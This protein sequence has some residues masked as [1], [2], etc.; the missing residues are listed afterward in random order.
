LKKT[1]KNKS[2]KPRKK[3]PGLWSS[4]DKN[5]STLKKQ[6]ADRLPKSNLS[7][8]NSCIDELFGMVFPQ[9]KRAIFYSVERSD[10]NTYLVSKKNLDQL[11]FKKPSFV[12]AR[13]CKVQEETVEIIKIYGDEKHLYDFIIEQA[14]LRNHFKKEILETL[15]KEKVPSLGKRKDLRKTPFVTID[16]VDAKDF[17]DAVYANL[18]PDGTWQLM[19]AIADVTHYLKQSSDLD[20]EA[21]QRGNSI[22]F[23]GFVIP[24]L[25]EKLSNDLCSLKPNVDRAVLVCEMRLNNKGEKIQHSFY[26]ALIHSHAR[27]TYDQVESYMDG[28]ISVKTRVKK[29][30][31]NLVNLYELLI[32]QREIR[33]PL[34]LESTELIFDFNQSGEVCAVKNAPQLQSQK[35]IEEMMVLAN[36]C[37]AE[38]LTEAQLKVPYRIHEMP[39]AEKIHDLKQQLKFY[40][41]KTGALTTPEGF[42]KIIESMS[43]HPMRS[44]IMDLCLRTQSKAIYDPENKGHFGLNL[45]H[46]CHFTSPIRRYADVLV[47]RAIYAVIQG[48]TN[49]FKSDYL[50][51]SDICYELSELERKATRVE[52]E[53]NDRLVAFFYANNIGSVFKSVISG[54]SGAGI[55][56]TVPDPE[57]SGLIVMENLSDDYYILK[58]NPVHLKG[59]RRGKVYRIGQSIEVVLESVD[60]AKGRLNFSIKSQGSL[61][62]KNK[63]KKPFIRKA[64]RTSKLN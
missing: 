50:D 45:K 21:L 44:T 40:Q 51:M 57:I 27:L 14:N 11:T 26:S 41:L 36:R 19:V 58:N 12:K 13:L 42:N 43:N 55:F 1:E 16:G 3:N 24:M 6:V 62:T 53:V 9:D 15:K 37:A 52:R 5:N 60:L 10:R 23:P 56:V 48:K 61:R 28:K 2:Y 33:G 54:I 30:V 25:P 39:V 49:K 7:D 22:Y 47:H 18:N 29:P 34:E 38:T 17:D 59:R 20:K 4:K 31:Q 64:R 63:E 35:L 46:Y 32:K 8:K